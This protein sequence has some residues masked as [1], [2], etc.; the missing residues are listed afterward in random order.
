MTR[1]LNDDS[2]AKTRLQRRREESKSPIISRKF[3]PES[4]MNQ[5]GRRTDEKAAKSRKRKENT[6]KNPEKSDHF[7]KPTK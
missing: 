6:Q 2:D 4:Y 5:P 1:N 7:L 3:E